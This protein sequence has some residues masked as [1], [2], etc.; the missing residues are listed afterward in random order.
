MRIAWLLAAV[1]LLGFA[2]PAAAA[3]GSRPLTVLSF[4][5]HHGAGLDGVFDLDRVADEIRR[6]GADI[7]GLQ[8]VDRHF[9]ERSEWTDGPAELASRLGMHVVYGANL[10]LEPPAPGQPRRQYGTAILSRHPILDWRNTLLPKGNPDEEQRGLL[11]AV[12][13]VRG[14]QVLAMTTHLQHDNAD[15]RLLQARAVADAVRAAQEPVVLTGDLNAPPTEP[16]IT[17][18]TALLRDSH[19]AGHG[20]GFTHPAEAPTARIDYVLSDGRPIHSEVLPTQASDHRP[21]LAKIKR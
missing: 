13:E 1:L 20:D 18:L 4:N 7:V 16:E 6:T 14:Q 10:D 21:V 2:T 3:P 19:A 11:E 8:E 12:I 15:S 9:S 5:I 17:T